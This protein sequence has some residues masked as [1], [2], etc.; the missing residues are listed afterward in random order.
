MTI[1]RVPDATLALRP[2]AIEPFRHMDWQKLWLAIQARSWCSL[3]LVPASSGAS[4]DLTLTIAT[5][6]ARTGMMHLGCPIQVADATQVSLER[7]VQFMSEIRLLQQEGGLVLV[8]LPPLSVNPV[9]VSLAQFT[10]CALLC[11]LL[12]LMAA[13]EAKKTVDL[14]APARFL[15]SAVFLPNNATGKARTSGARS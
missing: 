11:V 13:A 8:A 2:Q 3:A 5:T 4:P 10:D 7:L 14:I 1:Q 9:S 12:E 15:G 6:L